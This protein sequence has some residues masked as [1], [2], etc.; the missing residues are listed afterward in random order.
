MSLEKEIKELP[1]PKCKK[2]IKISMYDMY[3]KKEAKCSSCK[4]M[5]KFDSSAASNLRSALTSMENAEK[6]FSDAF[7][8]L[9]S[10]ADIT[11][12]H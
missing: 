3:T 4:S 5:Y 10:T 12:A 1:C 8:K 7:Q 9:I 11:I 2:A 6:K